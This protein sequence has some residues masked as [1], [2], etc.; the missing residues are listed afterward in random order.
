MHNLV[1]PSALYDDLTEKEEGQNAD[2]D[3]AEPKMFPLSTWYCIRVCELRQVLKPNA[4]TV[5]WSLAVLDC[6]EEPYIT[7]VDSL[8]KKFRAKAYAVDSATR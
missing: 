2:K 1:G 3:E 8:S 6:V 4:A 7:A 5:L